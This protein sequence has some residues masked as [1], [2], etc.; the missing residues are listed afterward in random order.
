MTSTSKPNDTPTYS[1][2]PQPYPTDAGTLQTGAWDGGE[3][4]GGNQ[5]EVREGLPANVR[6]QLS[7]AGVSLIGPNQYSVTLSLSGADTVQLTPNGADARQNPTSAVSPNV[8]TWGYVSRNVKVATVT[9]NGLVTAV[10]RGECEIV[11]RSFRQVNASFVGATP[12]GTESVDAS[13]LVTV[14]A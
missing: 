6:T 7:G 8:L 9:S 10:G 14:L 1:G 11:I 3:P 2:F 5:Q 4:A 13:L 12:S